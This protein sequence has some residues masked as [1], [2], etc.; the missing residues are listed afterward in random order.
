MFNRYRKSIAAL[1]GAVA[2]WGLAASADG[3]YDQAE[4]WALVAAVGTVVAVWG[5]PND[6]PPGEPADPNSSE[7]ETPEPGTTLF[8]Y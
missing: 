4:W 7:R 8:H 2:T 1:V 3:A 5:I 6:P